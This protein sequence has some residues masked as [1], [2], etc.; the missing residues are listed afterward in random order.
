MT[1]RRA[2]SE[3]ASADGLFVIEL[4]RQLPVSPAR[5]FVAWTDA[6]EM[7]QWWGPQ[8]V[9]C[10]GA[11][12]DLRVGG[13]YRIGNQLPDKREIWIEGTFLVVD[14]PHRLEYTWTTVRGGE[15]RERVAVQFLGNELG[16]EI[17]IRHSRIVDNATVESHRH[18]WLG[19]LAGLD[20]HLSDDRQ[21]DV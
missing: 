13:S 1:D 10:I 2:Q 19:C 6:D 14:P 18:G 3:S 4:R 5:A 9:R 8:G 15:A 20:R 7:L 17:V 16:T 12:V 21:D 11:E